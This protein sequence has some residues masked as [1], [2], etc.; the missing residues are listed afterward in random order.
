MGKT[1][2]KDRIVE[3]FGAIIEAAK[4]NYSCRIGLSGNND[5]LDSLAMG[6]N[7]MIDDVRNSIR[8]IEMQ[9][10]YM[11]NVITSM[12]DA[13]FVVS[14]EGIIQTV[15][16]AACTLLDYEEQN[17][18]IQLLNRAAG[19]YTPGN[20]IG[21][22]VYDYVSGNGH[23]TLQEAIEK[24]FRTGEPVSYEVL[25]AGLLGP[26]A[27]LYETRLG[28][29]VLGGKVAAA[30]IIFSDITQ[31]RRL[32]KE[33]LEISSRE[34]CRIGQDLHDGIC[35]LLIGITLMSKLI[36]EK[37]DAESSSLA[38]D[39]KAVTELIEQAIEQVHGLSKGLL[40]VPEK[41]E[42]LVTALKELAR[43][44]EE[45]YGV[46][47]PFKCDGDIRV[48]DKTIATHLYRIVQEAVN[49]AIKHGNAEQVS[50]TLAAHNNGITLAVE[51]DGL[52]FP[53]LSGTVE[54]LGLNIM[55]Y[56]AR[57]IGASLDVGRKSSGGTIVK[58]TI[59]KKST[60]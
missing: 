37:L 45:M 57:E 46:S 15:N 4:G 1:L 10:N 47:C 34:Q 25:G 33:I 9:R 3:M 43:N 41:A 16:N 42:G 44:T 21:T 27:A 12:P 54:G 11:D 59:R 13:L 49:N 2:E 22:S 36:E 50:I 20:I 5:A 60:E 29:V 32:E 30:T 56:R 19:E 17:G 52:D 6:F 53:E 31:H 24:V 35:Q 14:P 58:C 23:N 48:Q 8:E 7:M 40:P 18:N 28:P 39:V 51:N 26:D 55:E 38:R